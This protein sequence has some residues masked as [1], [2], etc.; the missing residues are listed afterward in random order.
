MFQ[1][2]IRETAKTAQNHERVKVRSTQ[3]KKKLVVSKKKSLPEN[4][5][6]F[7]DDPV[8]R[9]FGMIKGSRK[10]GL[11]IALSKESCYDV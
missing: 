5:E 2:R 7:E 3:A 9:S 4:V 6:K 8:A 10:L 1:T 11:K